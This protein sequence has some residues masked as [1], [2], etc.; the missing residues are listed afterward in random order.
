MLLPV[1]GGL[2]ML[3]KPAA[4]EKS[5]RIWCE[6]VVCLTSLCVWGA[7]AAGRTE[8]FTVYYFSRGFSV[9]FQLDGLGMLFSG[10]VS[11]MWPFVTL[12][13]YEYMNR[14]EHRNKFFAVYIM[15][16]GVTLGVAFA[17]N[18][19]TLYVF[20]E[21][22]SLVTIPLVTHYQDHDSMFAGRVY[23]G[24]VI[25]GAALAFLTVTLTTML[26]ADPFVWGGFQFDRFGRNFILLVYLIGF[27]GF[28]VKAA[29]LPFHFWLPAATVAPTPVTALLHAVAVV[30][31]GVF[32]V[33]RLTWYVFRPS[34]LEGTWAQITALTVVSATLFYAAGR[35][36]RERHFKRRLAYSTVSNL[37]YMLFGVL[38]LNQTGFQAGMA[39]M[40]FHGVI[41]MS[42]FLCAGAFMHQ[43]GCSYI[44]EVNG[45][46][47]KMPL[48]FA[49][50]TVGA[51]SL[52]GIPL[53]CGFVSKWRLLLAGAEAASV[54]AYIGTAC[55]IAAAFFCAIYTLSVSVR[56]YFPMEGKDRWKEQALSDPGWRMLIPIG[57]FSAVNILFGVLPE[58]VLGFLGRIASGSL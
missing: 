17:G 14:A 19:L 18:I 11:A 44:Y 49:F 36:L 54:S 23:A 7:L 57:L 10:M 1:A 4:T 53:L 48:T 56:A 40:L 26:S 33:M 50:Y 12:Y 38:L 22:L 47:R 21:M 42:L 8:P 13:A 15:T 37:S 32:A 3:W 55:L 45:A 43:S 46:G 30:N 2:W 29:V 34:D 24:Y 6:C 58:P 25:G 51:M 31:S 28:G 5:R 35:A 16:Y 39:H 20:F 9:R 27:F 41:K 52:T